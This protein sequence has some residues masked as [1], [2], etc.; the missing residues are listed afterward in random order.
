MKKNS[1]K[2][3]A[4]VCFLLQNYFNIAY[5]VSNPSL[6]TTIP[7]AEIIIEDVLIG[8]GLFIPPCWTYN[9]ETSYR[10]AAVAGQ[11][12]M[13]SNTNPDIA[14][15]LFEITITT[16]GETTNMQAYFQDGNWHIR[17]GMDNTYSCDLNNPNICYFSPISGSCQW[18]I[19]PFIT[20]NNGLN[21]ESIEPNCSPAITITHSFI[22]YTCAVNPTS[23]ASPN[24]TTGIVNLTL[25]CDINDVGKLIV[26]DRFG[27]IIQVINP[28]NL[29]NGTIHQTI[30]LT[31][32]SSGMY[33]INVMRGQCIS[34][35]RIKKL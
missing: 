22:Q 23:K 3:L 21:F 5:A 6:T 4:I 12:I 27:N 35:F 20:A 34:N 16:L 31:G 30:N 18:K 13:Y 2:T 8:G 25:D 15:E 9:Q 32:Q 14:N 24:P 26:F 7:T 17:K 10:G 19:R 28:I 11:G 29:I 33:Y 1:I